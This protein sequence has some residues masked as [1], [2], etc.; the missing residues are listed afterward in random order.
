MH[1]NERECEVAGL[2]PQAVARIARRL[3]RAAKAAEGLGLQI[4]G[5]SGSGDLRVL[6][7]EIGGR[8]G[9]YIVVAEISGGAWSGGEGTSS[10]GPDGLIR[11]E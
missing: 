3:E 1:V 5:G 6:G 4:F 11:G 9:G 2:D 8:L 7:S 10:K